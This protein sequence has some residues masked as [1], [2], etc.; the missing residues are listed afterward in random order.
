M[1]I[2]ENRILTNI[3][4]FTVHRLNIIRNVVNC[5]IIPTAAYH[6]LSYIYILNVAALD[7]TIIPSCLHFLMQNIQQSRGLG[8]ASRWSNVN[9]NQ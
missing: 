6:I 3:S 1:Y 4:D 5:E 2:R 7:E 8:L 9:V